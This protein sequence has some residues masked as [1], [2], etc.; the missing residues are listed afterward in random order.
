M[1]RNL[2]T[3]ILAR[4]YPIFGEITEEEFELFF[5]DQEF[6]NKLGFANTEEEVL[7][8]FK[9]FQLERLL[10]QEAS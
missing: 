2:I 6:V 4:D 7:H 3:N 10:L 5:N 9:E 8:L 1:K